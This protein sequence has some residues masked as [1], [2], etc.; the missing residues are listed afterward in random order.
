MPKASSLLFLATLIQRVWLR[1]RRCFFDLWCSVHCRGS[2]TELQSILL[3]YIFSCKSHCYLPGAHQP[4]CSIQWVYL[5]WLWW[6]EYIRCLHGHLQKPIDF[7]PMG[8]GY[9]DPF[10][11]RKRDNM[12]CNS[13]DIALDFIKILT[14]THILFL[15]LCFCFDVFWLDICHKEYKLAYYHK[16]GRILSN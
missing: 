14:K 9:N 2:L 7:Q 3:T 4:Q 10:I 15:L 5:P 11:L 1:T 13:A 8:V 16:Y 6:N 12:Q